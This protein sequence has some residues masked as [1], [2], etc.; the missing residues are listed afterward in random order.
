M[1]LLGMVLALFAA[2]GLSA[3]EAGADNQMI[4]DSLWVLFAAALVFFMQA[5][6][7]LLEGGLHS[8]RNVVNILMKNVADFTLATLAFWA[9]GFGLMFGAGNALLGTSGF[10]LGGGEGVFDSLSWTIVP[11]ELKFFFQL[12]FAGTAATIVSGT[13]GG[14]VKFSTYL[15]F[16]LV[17]T[18]VIY[19]IIGHWI[20]GGGWLAAMGFWDFAGS[21]VVH[22]VGGFAALAGALVVGPRIG[23]YDRAGKPKAMPGH[24]MMFAALGVFV[25]WLGWF[26]FNGGSTMAATPEGIAHILMT[27]NIAAATGGLAAMFGSWVLFQKPDISMTLNGVLAGLVSITAPCAFV[28]TGSAALIGLIGGTIVVGSIIWL[29]RVGIDDPVGAIAVHGI[30]GV[31]GTLSIGLFAS[32]PFAGGE[33][34]PGL[35]LLFG[36][37]VTQLYVQ[38]IGAFAG[39]GAAF[40]AAFALFTVLK[41]TLGLRVTPEEELAG[42]DAAEHGNEAYPTAH[43]PIHSPA[44]LMAGD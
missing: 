4:L 23:K 6:F 22:A 28:G 41:A 17:L 16:S 32:A 12:M 38:T 27:T 21:T 1:P 7:A 31:W 39:A 3:Q 37:G 14:R 13:V 5:G 33:A 9:I 36:G 20:W 30:C 26:G 40:V 11:L 15:I 43:H 18:A 29:E 8:S 24:N 2:S 42:L 44:V 19:P 10:L 35:G 34:L 25:L